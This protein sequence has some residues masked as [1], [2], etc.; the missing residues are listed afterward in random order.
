MFKNT[1]T[2][3]KCHTR[4]NSIQDS[5]RGVAQNREVRAVARCCESWHVL[6]WLVGTVECEA[7]D[8]KIKA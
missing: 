1:P 4:L 2:H 6:L 8:P 7:H 3:Y 5:N